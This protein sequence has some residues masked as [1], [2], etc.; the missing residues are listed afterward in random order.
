MAVG[1]MIAN[2][3]AAMTGQRLLPWGV[4]CSDSRRT[5]WLASGPSF[6]LQ[7]TLAGWRSGQRPIGPQCAPAH[8][9]PSV[10]HLQSLLAFSC[11]YLGDCHE[12]RNDC[13]DRIGAGSSR[14]AAHLGAQSKLGLR[15]QRDCRPDRGGD[16]RA[17]ADGPTVTSKGA[18]A[19][20]VVYSQAPS[21]Q[22]A[23]RW[24]PRE[25]SGIVCN[26]GIMPLSRASIPRAQPG[27]PTAASPPLVRHS[28]A[29]RHFPR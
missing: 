18:P 4:N 5:Q 13:V 17:A 14:G 26:A 11:V 21:A 3:P 24:R 29:M 28:S 7:T 19:L 6:P 15:A 23:R 1:G 22:R 16:G 9:L 25:L 8:R 12:F 27:G 2:L 10:L 20:Q